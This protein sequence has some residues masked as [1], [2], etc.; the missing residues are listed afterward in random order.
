MSTTAIGIE[1]DRQERIRQKIQAQQARNVENLLAARNRPYEQQLETARWKE[2]VLVPAMI[3]ARDRLVPK[4]ADIRGFKVPTSVRAI[5][6]G[7]FDVLDPETGRSVP[8][9]LALS[10]IVNSERQSL[11]L[12]TLVKRGDEARGKPLPSLSGP[13]AS[14]TSAD[15]IANAILDAWLEDDAA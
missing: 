7:T 6:H 15:A 5:M 3:Q 4:Y 12:K 11:H 9:E 10:F 2:D 1:D 8:P 13:L 14:F